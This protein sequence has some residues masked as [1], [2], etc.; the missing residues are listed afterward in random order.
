METDMTLE[1][2]AQGI[3]DLLAREGLKAAEVRDLG[4]GIV[5]AMVETD[6]IKVGIVFRAVEEEVKS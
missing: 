6:E 3:I 4:D 2:Q 1:D 5:G